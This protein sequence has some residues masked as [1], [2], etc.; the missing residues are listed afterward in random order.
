MRNPPMKRAA[1]TLA[2]VV[3]LCSTA[4][5]GDA[6]MR[7][8]RENPAAPVS[9]PPIVV[10]SV[11]C[12]DATCIA[13]ATG[14]SA[15]AGIAGYQWNWGDGTSSSGGPAMIHTYSVSGTYTVTPVVSDKKGQIASANQV[16]RVDFKPIAAFNWVC[17]GTTCTF[18]ATPSFDDHEI[19]TYE[20]YIDGAPTA[21]ADLIWTDSFKAGS[22]LK[23]TLEVTDNIGQTKTVDHKC[24]VGTNKAP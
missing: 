23:I 10:F 21:Y 5:A 1:W 4:F 8:V 11:V 12:D 2:I 7:G 6:R 17:K 15:D 14:S 20:W 22:K 19:S 24:V 16:I 18:D 13:D 3:A 9:R